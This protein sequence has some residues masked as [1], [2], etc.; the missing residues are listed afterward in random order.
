MK[1]GPH[2]FY[3]S[4]NIY[5]GASKIDSVKPSAPRQD[6]PGMPRIFGLP[7][8][9]RAE[10]SKYGQ[11]SYSYNP[12]FVLTFIETS[13]ELGNRSRVRFPRRVSLPVVCGEDP[14]LNLFL[15]SLQAPLK[16]SDFILEEIELMDLVVAPPT[17]PSL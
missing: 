9:E 13:L 5:G 16:Y 1:H 2:S 11:N 15:Q 4:V 3:F 7:N 6:F 17:D 10:Y 14:R 12:E 8:T